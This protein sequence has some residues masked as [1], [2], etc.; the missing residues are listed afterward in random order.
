LIIISDEASLEK[1]AG[2]VAKE[3]LVTVSMAKDSDSDSCPSKTTSC[4]NSPLIGRGERKR[5]SDAK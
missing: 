2:G 3:M 5:E 4:Q 1:P